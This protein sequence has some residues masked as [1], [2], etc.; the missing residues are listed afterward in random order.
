MVVGWP[1]NT[2]SNDT[3]D[4]AGL[5]QRAAG[6]VG[7]SLGIGV[8][9]GVGVSRVRRRA[10]EIQF[11][12]E[13]IAVVAPAKGRGE[14]ARRGREVVGVGA[15]GDV[16][17][18]G[19]IHRDAVARVSIAPAEVRG[20]DQHGINDQRLMP[21]VS[22]DL[23]TDGVIRQEDVA[24]LYLVFRPIHFL[25]DH[26]LDLVHVA[27]RKTQD[28]ITDAVHLHA[29]CPRDRQPDGLR[30]CPRGDN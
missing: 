9:L 2:S 23:E 19:P 27:T 25:V 13:G 15:A 18:P 26:G 29:P 14:G 5:T 7:V 22:T 21:V 6:G 11:R 16:G 3:D 1:Q 30:C 28:D 8:S 10:R 24:P 17:R 4:E 20:V 12:H